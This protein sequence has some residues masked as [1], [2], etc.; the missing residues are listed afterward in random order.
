[1]RLRARQSG[2]GPDTRVIGIRSIGTG[3]AAIVAAALGAKRPFTVRPVGHPFSRELRIGDGL[4]E[5]LLADPHASFAIVDEGPG[6]SGSS[7]A[8][9]IGW[10]RDNDVAPAAST[11]SPAMAANRA[12]KRARACM[13]PGRR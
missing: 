1:M 6:L 7:F 5:Q 13:K 12:R 2:L 4:K 10:L 9:V 11:S 3:L 8:A